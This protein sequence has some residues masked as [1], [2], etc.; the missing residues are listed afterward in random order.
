M[1]KKSK[2]PKRDKKLDV[3]VMQTMRNRG[4]FNHLHASLLT[5]VADIVQDSEY[6]AFKPYKTIK[7]DVD[8]KIAA[9][10]VMEYLKRHGMT[11]TLRCIAIET[12]NKLAPKPPSGLL[13]KEL[14][15]DVQSGFIEAI[16][17]EWNKNSD[18]Y[19]A[20]NDADLQ[21]TIQQR[22]QALPLNTKK[23]KASVKTSQPPP[24][25]PVEG[26]PAKPSEYHDDSVIPAKTQNLDSFDDAE[27]FDEPPPTKPKRGKKKGGKKKK[28]AANSPRQQSL[29]QE[30][31][32]WD[33]DDQ[34]S[35]PKASMTKPINDDK[36]LDNEF[37]DDDD[38]PPMTLKG[39]KTAN[40]G[41]AK[42]NNAIKQPSRSTPSTNEFDDDD[43]DI[44]DVN[45][46]DSLDKLPPKRTAPRPV[47]SK[48]IKYDDDDDFDNELL[49]GLESDQPKKSK[50]APAKGGKKPVG[51]VKK[52]DSSLDSAD[53]ELDFD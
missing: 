48:P 19:L 3:Q 34:P 44:L 37:D 13:K 53:L 20:Q 17:E 22:L 47:A 43:E 2:G 28:A 33:N 49:D 42:P 38:E 7:D 18:D 8:S 14:N 24:V 41:K 52:T 5:D 36:S 26:T 9:E 16:H 45:D 10:I 27:D 35:S 32:S 6:D 12:R 25:K 29:D 50:A 4:I 21:Q 40:A 51:K 31:E 30:F 23:A 39:K 15:I 11:D 1:S 46:D